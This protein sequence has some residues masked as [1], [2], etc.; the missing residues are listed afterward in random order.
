MAASELDIRALSSMIRVPSTRTQAVDE[1][2]RTLVRLLEMFVPDPHTFSDLLTETG[3]ILTGQAALWFMMRDNGHPKPR[4]L[5]IC[6]P[7]HRFETV[8]GF[9]LQLPGALAH[10]FPLDRFLSDENRADCFGVQRRM[11]VETEKGTLELLESTSITALHPVPFQYGTHLM[12][13]L[14]PRHFISPYASLT[15]KKMAFIPPL[16]GRRLSRDLPTHDSTR[17]TFW[18]RPAAVS[19]VEQ[20]CYMFPACSKRVRTFADDD[21]LVIPCMTRSG[22][23]YHDIAIESTCTA[24][25]LGGLPCENR[26]CFLEV[27]RVVVTE[28]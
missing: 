9:L 15:L 19:E 14:S 1:L 18:T 20:T 24:W 12:N 5:T 10:P 27:E 23:S 2:Q 4:T 26:R 6:C 8:Y 28:T 25:R 11:L 7:L 17:F 13:M 16:F 3:S 21:C 22:E